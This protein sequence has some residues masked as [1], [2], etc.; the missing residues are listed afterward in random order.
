MKRYDMH[1]HI[2]SEKIDRNYLLDRM[3]EAGIWGGGLIS[4]CPLESSADLFA[5]PYR[6]RLRNILSWTEPDDRLIPI[7]WVHPRE[8]DACDIVKDAAASGV[9]AFKM[10]CD[11]YAVD[12]PE[13]MRLLA[14]IEQTGRPVIFHSGIL[15]AG[16]DSSKYNR[17][18]NWECMLHFPEIKFALAPCSWPWYDE[19]IA[20]Y[21][22]FLNACTYRQSSEMFFDLTPG[23]PVI[24]RKD[25][26]TKLWRVGYDAQDNMMFGSDS[27]SDDYNVEWVK[28]WIERDD[29][30]YDELGVTQEQREKIYHDNFLRM[31]EGR[32][33]HHILPVFNKDE[34]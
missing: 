21:G 14:A 15:W 8:K 4:A 22:K 1:I 27:L 5:L 19:C 24:Y 7:M 20:V 16:L 29:A 6:D 17:P 18:V 33:I 10:I 28:S 11:N 12:C 31:I 34:R 2:G 13:S 23:T 30:I 32:S 9:K 26:L 3:E 25:L